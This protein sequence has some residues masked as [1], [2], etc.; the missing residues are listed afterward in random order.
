VPPELK[1]MISKSGS[2]ASAPLTWPPPRSGGFH[3]AEAPSAFT[4]SGTAWCRQPIIRSGSSWP[5]TWRTETGKGRGAFRMQRSG[6]RMWKGER[7][8]QLFGIS[9]ATTHL[10]PKQE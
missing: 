6:I 1:V 4:R 3:S 10:M 2:S 8:A 5:T 9:G 7:E